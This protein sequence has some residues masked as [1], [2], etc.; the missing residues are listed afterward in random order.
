MSLDGELREKTLL[1]GY[2]DDRT[3]PKIEI[4]PSKGGF[5]ESNRD[6]LKVPFALLILQN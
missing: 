2:F 5:K 4:Y 1:E 3:A 6:D